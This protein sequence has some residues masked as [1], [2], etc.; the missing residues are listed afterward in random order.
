MLGLQ[1]LKEHHVHFEICPTS[2]VQTDVVDTFADHPIDLLYRA[3]HSVSVNTDGRTLVNTTLTEEYQRLQKTFGWQKKDFLQVNLHAAHHAFL[4][5][6]EKEELLQ[7]LK[8][9]YS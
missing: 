1:K 4:A 2:N 5:K 9:G 8:S 7:K 6:A 3:G